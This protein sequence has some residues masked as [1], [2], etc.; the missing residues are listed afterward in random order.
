MQ[1]HVLKIILKLPL[2]ITMRKPTNQITASET[3]RGPWSQKYEN[4]NCK[5]Y[6]VMEHSL[7]K[8]VRC[9]MNVY[10]PIFQEEFYL[11][12][13]PLVMDERLK[14]WWDIIRTFWTVAYTNIEDKSFSCSK[15]TST[16]FW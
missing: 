11:E 5:L 13:R 1:M 6:N 9:C 8:V 14:Y 10:R 2:F 7:R 15:F 4:F 16:C 3:S 12:S